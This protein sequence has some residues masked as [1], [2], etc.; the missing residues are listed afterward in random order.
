MSAATGDPGRYARIALAS[1]RLIN[2]GLALLAPAFLARRVGSDPATDVGLLYVFR[3]F[4]IRTVLIGLDLL[5]GDRA[6]RA[7]AV[8][9]ALPIHASDTV[10]ALLA[11]RTGRLGQSGMLLV[12]ISA[13]NTL[14]AALARRERQ[15]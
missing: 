4:G 10:A 1:I 15:L 13:L 12:G 6:L 3:M 5:G 14:L 2:G 11:A 9:Q 8:Q 7:H